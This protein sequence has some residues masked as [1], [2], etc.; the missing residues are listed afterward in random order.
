MFL[1]REV[2]SVWYAGVTNTASQRISFRELLLI[3]W[4]GRR[5]KLGSYF[6]IWRGG[7]PSIFKI[8]PGFQTR[9]LAILGQT[10]SNLHSH[11][12]RKL[13]QS[14]STILDR[15]PRR[16]YIIQH[17]LFEFSLNLLALFIRCRFAMKVKESTEIKFR[18]LQKLYLPNMDL[19]YF[20]M[21]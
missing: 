6:V 17:R 12:A 11:Q 18:R 4:C 8:N 21:P 15:T 20:S 10:L 1:K 16:S 2:R 7:R 5:H 9:L 3:V 19:S 13:T 14:I